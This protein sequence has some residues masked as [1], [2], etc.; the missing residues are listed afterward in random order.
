MTS[1]NR[2]VAQL[3]RVAA[4]LTCDFEPRKDLSQEMLMHLVRVETDIP[5]RT[6]SWY[7]KSC[8]FRARN[9]LQHGRS[10]DSIKRCNNL[11]PLDPNDGDRDGSF[12]FCWE[13]ADPIDLHGELIAQDIVDLLISQLTDM[14]QQIL[15]LL[16]HGFSVRETARKLSVS[17][18]AV[19]KHRRKIARI[20]SGLL[21]D[22][23]CTVPRDGVPSSM[24]RAGNGWI[25]EVSGGVNTPWVNTP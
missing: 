21:R 24:P 4:R 8:E 7:I 25:R 18:P 9:Y 2:I 16:M 23:G 6:R 12:W 10:V 15:S 5:G 14:Q 1:D 20:A 22:S 11:V 3:R 13:A 19:I 17:H